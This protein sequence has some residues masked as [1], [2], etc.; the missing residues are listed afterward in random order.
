MPKRTTFEI[1]DNPVSYKGKLLR[2]Y[3]SYTDSN[4]QSNT[5]L[6]DDVFTYIEFYFSSHTK[7]LKYRNPSSKSKYG[8]EKKYHYTFYWKQAMTFYYAT[9]S[10][11]IESVPLLSYYSMLNAAKAFLSF[12]SEYIEDFVENFAGHGLFENVNLPGTDLNTIAVGRKNKGV[13]PLFGKYLEQNFDT[14]WPSGKT[15]TITLKKLLYNLAYIH[16]AYIT[17]YNT[18]RSAKIPELFIPV[19]AFKSPCYHKGNDGNIYLVINIDKSYFPSNSVAIPPTYISSISP[20]FRVS[21][22]ENFILQSVKGARWNN[23]ESLSSD[24]K[25]LNKELRQEFQYIRSSKRLWYLRRSTLISSDIVKMNSMLITMAAMHRISE[26]VRY[27]P[28]QLAHLMKSKENWLLHE[29]IT[30]ALDQFIDEIATEI[31]GQ[32]IMGTGTKA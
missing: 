20:E 25:Q 4:F 16:R 21:H 8:S 13:F 24:F 12:K 6:T 9:K 23:T 7:A 19:V 29:F 31:T 17:T 32:D 27:K 18:P 15:N 28:E 10:L 11:P 22:K 5:I 2:M 3:K 14:I 26:I 1:S 30:L